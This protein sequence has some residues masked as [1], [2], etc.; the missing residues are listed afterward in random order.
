MRRHSEETLATNQEEYKQSWHL[1]LVLYSLQNY[2]KCIVLVY[3]PPLLWYFVTAP[4][5][6]NHSEAQCDRI[7]HIVGDISGK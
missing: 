2:E 5:N 1:D 7:G 6:D 3:K 4:Q